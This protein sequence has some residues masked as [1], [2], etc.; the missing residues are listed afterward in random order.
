MKLGGMYLNNPLD[1]EQLGNNQN[2]LSQTL[3]S[4]VILVDMK[5]KSAPIAY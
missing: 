4:R 2:I 3:A 1:A 5:R